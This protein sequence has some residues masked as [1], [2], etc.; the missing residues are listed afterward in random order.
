MAADV[1]DSEFM[2]SEAPTDDGRNIHG[3]V[4]V[5]STI[6]QAALAAD[7]ADHRQV[8]HLRAGVGD[9][10]G[11]HHAGIRPDRLAHLRRVGRVHEADFTP[12]SSSVP[13]RLLVLPNTYWLDTR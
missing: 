10:L 2:T 4:S 6:D 12:S 7:L 3:E 1:L 5:L 9:G 8:G 11:E 13:S